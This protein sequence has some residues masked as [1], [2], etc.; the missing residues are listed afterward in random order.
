[1]RT[2]MVRAMILMLMVVA[3]RELR[4]LRWFL[5]SKTSDGDGDG[6]GKVEVGVESRGRGYR[7]WYISY[8]VEFFRAG[9]VELLC[10]YGCVT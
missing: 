2:R 8:C 1:M 10:R 4:R 3:S 9:R 6:D 5:S 7:Q